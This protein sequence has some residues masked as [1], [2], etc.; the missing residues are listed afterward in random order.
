MTVTAVASNN[1]AVLGSSVSSPVPLPLAGLPVAAG[2]FRTLLEREVL[3][4]VP[5][6]TAMATRSASAPVVLGAPCRLAVHGQARQAPGRSFARSSEDPAEEDSLDPL[7]RHRAALAPPAMVGFSPVMASSLPGPPTVAAP[8]PSRSLRS[9]ED[10]IPAL[11]RRVAWSGDGRRGTAR[12]EIGAGELSGATL[13]V[14]ADGGHV[15][16]RLDV[17]AGVSASAWRQRIVERLASRS[18]PTDAVE[19]E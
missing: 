13:L 4:R 9:L 1:L 18:I 11:V 12:I 10:L 19:V 5:V 2:T 3:I 15:R 8:I 6:R 7:H 16:V 17:P 14:H